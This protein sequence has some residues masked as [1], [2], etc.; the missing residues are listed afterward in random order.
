MVETN[1][2]RLASLLSLL[3]FS[4]S[5]PSLAAENQD[6]IPVK[7]TNNPLRKLE[8]G[9]YGAMN[10]YDFNWQTDS[11]KRDAIDQEFFVAELKYHWTDRIRLNAE[12][13]FEHGGRVL[14]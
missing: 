9:G 4:L 10:Y 11:S 3:L 8:L 6:T 5:F 13:E 1:P 2:L 14:L 7:A 12:I